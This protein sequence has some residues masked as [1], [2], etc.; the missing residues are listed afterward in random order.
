MLWSLGRGRMN[1]WLVCLTE[2]GE[3]VAQS[4]RRG[5]NP[6]FSMHANVSSKPKN[7]SLNEPA[8]K[9]E[10]PVEQA[11]VTAGEVQESPAMQVPVEQGMP[12]TIDNTQAGNSRQVGNE[13]SETDKELDKMA[14][15]LVRNYDKRQRAKKIQQEKL[16]LKQKKIASGSS[17]V[18]KPHKK[19]ASAIPKTHKRPRSVESTPS[20]SSVKQ[21]STHRPKPK[22]QAQSSAEG[23][24][25]EK[26]AVTKSGF[27]DETIGEEDFAELQEA[28]YVLLKPLPDGCSPRFMDNKLD[29]GA[30]VF[31]CANSYTRNWLVESVGKISPWKNVRLEVGEASNILN[32]TRVVTTLPPLFNE[33]K[34]EE[35][36]EKVNLQNQDVSTADW[37]VLKATPD[38]KGMTVVIALNQ[39]DLGKL[40][41]KQMKLFVSFGQVQFKILG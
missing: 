14:L 39:A 35:F 30:A 17:T 22:A 13:N 6:I 27:P 18:T 3:N 32:T 11:P 38:P 4:P 5:K 16:V 26:M 21:P 1:I 28:L 7:P 33:R 41:A 23:M 15:R 37:R 2:D 24:A 12:M 9:E 34:V 19:V 20:N 40:K 29:G 10:T 31:Y 36:L 8:V 25:I